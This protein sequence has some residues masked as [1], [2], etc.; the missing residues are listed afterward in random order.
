ML[1]YMYSWKALTTILENT[2]GA[3]LSPKGI[4]LYAKDRNS[5]RNVV[6][7]LVPDYILKNHL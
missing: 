7:E 3:F 1:L 4:F 5:H 6:L 2:A